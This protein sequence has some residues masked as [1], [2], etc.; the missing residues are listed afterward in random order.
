[1]RVILF[2]PGVNGP[3]EELQHSI[4]ELVG[5]NNLEIFRTITNFT[6]RLQQPVDNPTVAVLAAATKEDLADILAIRSW[7]ER[8]K[9]IVVLPDNETETISQGHKLHPR[10]L[11][12][13]DSDFQDVAAVL[14]KMLSLEKY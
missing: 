14:C 9:V 6:Q 3:I 8:V 13:A 5:S 1:M 7:L 2:T 10:F 11:T 12:Y 4:A